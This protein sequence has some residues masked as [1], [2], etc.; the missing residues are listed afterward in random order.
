[1]GI[2]F[3][4]CDLLFCLQLNFPCIA[5][6]NSHKMEPSGICKLR[7][8]AYSSGLLLEEVFV[9]SASYFVTNTVE[10]NTS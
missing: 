3:I 1:M 9:V 4:N 10:E 8:Q 6:I 2:F 5:K 7:I